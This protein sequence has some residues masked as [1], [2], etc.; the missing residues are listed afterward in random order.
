MT[1][2]H[3]DVQY[4]LRNINGKAKFVPCSNHN[5]NSY[6][7]HASD[8]KASAINFGVIEISCI[9]FSPSNHLWEV[10]SSNVEV[11]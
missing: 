7:V 4:L 5:L 3:G 8:G 9:F 6:G 10:L 1:G 2:V 11:W